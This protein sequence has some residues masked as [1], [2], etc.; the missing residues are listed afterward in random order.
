MAS[1]D[2][3]I[4]VNRGGRWT[5]E[6]VERVEA[7]AIASAKRR[8]TMPGVEAVKVIQEE[9]NRL[10]RVKQNVIFEQQG[11]TG[12]S[13]VITVAAIDA[14]PDKCEEPADLYEGGARQT[15]AKLFRN[16]T[17]KMNLTVSEILYNARELKRVMEKDNLLSSAVAKV[18]SLQAGTQDQQGAKTRRDELFTMIDQVMA[19]ANAAD[20]TELPSIAAIGFE[21]LEKAVAGKAADPEE[22][23]YLLRVAISRDL[24]NERSFI[25]KLENAVNWIDSVD[26]KVAVGALDD[27]IA[28]VLTDATVIQ[29]VLG[30]RDNLLAAIFAMLDLLEGQLTVA[31]TPGM[32]EADGDPIGERLNKLIGAARLPGAAA[33][34][35]DR[36]QTM[37]ASRNPLVREASEQEE[38]DALRTLAERFIPADGPVRTGPALLN[39]LLDRGVNMVNKGGDTGRKEAVE[40]IAGLF[41]E[42]GRK[43]RFLL[44]AHKA[45]PHDLIREHTAKVLQ[46]WRTGMKSATDFLQ[47]KNPALVMR[48]VTNLFYYVRDVDSPAELKTPLTQHLEG[49]LYDY[50]EKAQILKMVDDPNRPLRQ[51]ARLLMSMC[52]P[53]MLPP[54]KAVEAAR[55]RVVNYL[56]QPDFTTQVVADLTD[57]KEQEAALRDLFDLMRRAGFKMG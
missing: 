25:G 15:M 29:D 3:E 19:K 51:R 10:G 4:H 18:A 52:L 8:V 41:A 35:I 34:I 2:Y 54:G 48:A 6:S 40:Y 50:V 36:L 47:S 14:A 28:D 53:D 55:V 16:Y 45:T 56:R 44:A 20:K 9:S 17:S 33:V 49:L 13:G 26:P 43:I 32:P 22:R 38:K 1:A 12:D 5:I 57:P 37:I 21:A 39:A 11:R 23:N 42:Q 31:K 30:R 24:M 46:D 7:E 27:F